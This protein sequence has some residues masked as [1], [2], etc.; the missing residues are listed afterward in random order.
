MATGSYCSPNDLSIRFMLYQG[1][2]QTCLR[3][4]K[5]SPWTRLVNHHYLYFAAVYVLFISKHLEVAEL[6]GQGLVSSDHHVPSRRKTVSLLGL[7]DIINSLV[8][9]SAN[10]D[11]VA[12]ARVKPSSQGKSYW[13][14][15][16]IDILNTLG[17]HL[18][19]P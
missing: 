17:Q 10:K 9:A 13:Y 3:K 14:K 5:S 2:S 8:G 19:S 18:Q 1:S 16:T 4:E 6:S 15:P 11:R 12:P 7:K